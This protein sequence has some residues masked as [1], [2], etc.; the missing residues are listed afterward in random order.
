MSEPFRENPE[1]SVCLSCGEPLSSPSMDCPFCGYSSLKKNPTESPHESKSRY[2]EDDIEDDYRWPPPRQRR[3]RRGK[4]VE[5]TDFLVPTDVSGWAIASCYMGL[6]GF[7]LPVFGLLFAIPAV[8]FGYVALKKQK[9]AQSYGE[10]TSN[11]RAVIGIVLGSL[12]ILI[13]LFVL[14]LM[15]ATSMGAFK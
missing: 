10:V 14:I 15:A 9:R 2:I 1:A 8:I 13:S 12:G 7:C 11:A 4:S 5:A 3:P 6:I